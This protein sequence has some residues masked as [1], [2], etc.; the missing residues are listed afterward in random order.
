MKCIN[1][2]ESF[3]LEKTLA[4]MQI[5]NLK[6]GIYKIVMHRRNNFKI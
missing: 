6:I 1:V 4:Q 5:L 2:K 3:L